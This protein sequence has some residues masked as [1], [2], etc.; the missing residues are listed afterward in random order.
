MK[1]H[2]TTEERAKAS[3]DVASE[4][5]EHLKRLTGHMKELETSVDQ[6]GLMCL[7][8]GAL[9]KRAGLA[10]ISTKLAQAELDTLNLISQAEGCEEVLGTE[11]PFPEVEES[12]RQVCFSL[13]RKSRR[14]SE[15]SSSGAITPFRKD[16]GE[17]GCNMSLID[18]DIALTKL[19]KW[20]AWKWRWAA[21]AARADNLSKQLQNQQE[22]RDFRESE[23]ATCIVQREGPSARGQKMGLVKKLESSQFVDMRLL[24]GDKVGAFILKHKLVPLMMSAWRAFARMSGLERKASSR[25][26]YLNK[27]IS[28]LP[29]WI[30]RVGE[31]RVMERFFFHWQLLT[32]KATRERSNQ[33]YRR[34]IVPY[35]SPVFQTK[36]RGHDEDQSQAQTHMPPQPQVPVP[37]PNSRA[38]IPALVKDVEVSA[39]GCHHA[40]K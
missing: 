1:L 29:W 26:E 33:N 39:A 9:Q 16:A 37:N 3:E 35:V 4:M 36:G 18:R 32:L 40:K 13:D 30:R 22:S 25:N 38:L 11:L 19:K 12:K 17:P 23:G 31:R 20:T 28:A 5:V 7:Q 27:I 24:D 2:Y 21:A 6:N 34:K 10:K 15:R 14:R 8:P